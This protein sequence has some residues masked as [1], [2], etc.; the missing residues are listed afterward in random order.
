MKEPISINPH[1]GRLV[2]LAA[3]TGLAGCTVLS[4][5]LL[6]LSALNHTS[7]LSKS[8]RTPLQFPLEISPESPSL[9][10]LIVGQ[11]AEARIALRSRTSRP[12]EVHRVETSCPCLRV[13]P[14]SFKVAPG[15][16]AEVDLAF[17]PS[18]EPEFRGRLSIDVAGY[19]LGDEII[20]RTRVHFEVR[21]DPSQGMAHWPSGYQPR[22]SRRLIGF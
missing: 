6:R 9:G 18:Q 17:D 1:P 8:A 21:D 13:E 14:T 7:P 16:S 19:G 5:S 12:L 2:L 20:F 15:G 3:L 10:T 4:F 11:H 22:G